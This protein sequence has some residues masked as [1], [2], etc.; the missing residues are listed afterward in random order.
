MF[1]RY[2]I[3]LVTAGLFLTL[4]GETLL[5]QDAAENAASAPGPREVKVSGQSVQNLWLGH[6]KELFGDDASWRWRH[7][8]HGVTDQDA[9]PLAWEPLLAP[10]QTKHL[11]GD[12]VRTLIK[13]SDLYSLRLH[14]GET[15]MPVRPLV[16]MAALIPAAG[17]TVRVFVW[18][19]GEDTGTGG[20][21]WESAPQA[22]LVLR[23]GNGDQV[24]RAEGLFR[25]RGSFPWFC[26]YLDLQ[27]PLSYSTAT[28]SAAGGLFIELSNPVSGKAWFC[29]PSYVMLPANAAPAGAAPLTDALA[30][31]KLGTFAPN[32]DYDEL[33][34]HFMYGLPQGKGQQWNFMNGNVQFNSLTLN[35]N[36]LAYLRQYH[37]DWLHWTHAVPSLLYMYNVAAPLKRLASFEPGWDEALLAE[38]EAR[39]NPRTGLWPVGGRDNLLVT[40]LLA[41][42]C[43]A[44][45][46]LAQVGEEA[47]DTEWLSVKGKPLPQ[48][49][50][51][52]TSLLSAQ[53]RFQGQR[54]GWNKYAFQGEDLQTASRDV[55]AGDLVCTSS[56]MYLL[57][58]C[59]SQVAPELA[60]DIEQALDAAY[61]FAVRQLLNPTSWLWFA[62]ERQEA[63]ANTPL[64]YTL[65]E[66]SGVMGMRFSDA[67]QSFT[68]TLAQ[69]GAR[70]HLQ[71]DK[72]PEQTV[73]LRIYELHEQQRPDRLRPQQLV[74]IVQREEV[75]PALCDPLYLLK[76][77]ATAQEQEALDARFTPREAGSL[78]AEARLT[79]LRHVQFSQLDAK[80]NA[81]VPI[82]AR[83]QGK[84]LVVFAVDA[85]GKLSRPLL[86]K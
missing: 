8:M 59:K 74:A 57:A 62:D 82:P 43:F 80:G 48:A 53:R 23:D 86:V 51:L 44:P 6:E 71:A 26:Y 61:S 58:L 68:A 30:D 41:S 37:D 27:I 39:Q 60:K 19:K 36:L 79:M 10:E 12:R 14:G 15:V 50:R 85:T 28:A 25:T 17:S 78:F 84:P 76:Q 11:S 32:P 65:L 55:V 21:L 22:T 47:W 83:L 63:H 77:Y 52:A 5:S 34:L 2:S 7:F 20:T 67:P 42:N 1:S 9:T 66:A 40:Y 81:S 73:S 70:L 49:E 3:A 54:A 18:L 69:Q 56:A 13:S 16:D 35:G 64:A 46:S 33:P 29:T 75:L 31:P 4:A 45:T 38:L 24:T 72:L